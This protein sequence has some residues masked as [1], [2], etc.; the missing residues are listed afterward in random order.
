MKYLNLFKKTFALELSSEMAYKGNF[1]IKSLGLILADFI[2]P[3]VI[4]LIYTNSSGIRGWGFE[5]F[6]LFQGTFVLVTGLSHFLLLGLPFQ[7]IENVR[8]GT[9][10]KILIKPF[11][12]LIYLSFTSID[13]EGL[14]EVLA[15]LSLVIWGFIKLDILIVSFNTL[16]YIFL[17]LVAF[18]FLYAAFVLMSAMAFLFVKSFGLFDLFF[19]IIDVARYPL[20][21]YEGGMRFI[22]TFLLLR[23]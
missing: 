2:G 15:G 1:F 22:F 14:A 7:V 13:L 11:N 16:L 19:K 17:I 20:N 23:R 6:I 4:L 10:D 9:F 21:I 12:P 3:L 18:I 8:E 5:E